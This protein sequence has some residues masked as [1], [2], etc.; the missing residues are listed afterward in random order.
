MLV[1]MLVRLCHRHDKSRERSSKFVELC[2]LLI[3][4]EVGIIFSGAALKVGNV[5][6]YDEVDLPPTT[7][8]SSVIPTEPNTD[9]IT[10]TMSQTPP[11][12]T[13][14]NMAYGNVCVSHN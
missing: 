9:Y 5:A 13:H 4:C 12:T 14:H 3:I 8:S 10:T 6:V 7:F 11:I 2:V 1:L